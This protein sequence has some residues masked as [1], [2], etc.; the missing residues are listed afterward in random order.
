MAVGRGKSGN[1]GPAVGRSLVCECES[2]RPGQGG[3]GR[4]E[5]ARMS[6]REISRQRMLVSPGRSV[7]SV[8]EPP[9]A[10]PRPPRR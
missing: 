3:C 9:A 4:A 1:K 6:G 5:D 8:P 10:A 7:G 2:P